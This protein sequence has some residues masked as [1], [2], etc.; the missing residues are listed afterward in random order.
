VV[1]EFYAAVETGDLS[2]LHSYFNENYT[3]QDV[4]PMKDTRGSR[5]SETSSDIIEHIKNLREAIPGFRMTIN[6][7]LTEEGDVAFADVTMTGIQK[8]QFLG[9]ESTVRKITM[10][11]FVMYELENYK[12]KSTLEMWV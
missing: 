3:I 12:I 6:G 7:V 5:I 9:V 8:G 1:A 10:R 4:G 11:V 2:A